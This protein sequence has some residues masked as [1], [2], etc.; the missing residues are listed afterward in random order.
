MS[1]TPKKPEREKPKPVTAPI[2]QFAVD[3]GDLVIGGEPLSRLA[4]RIGATPFFR[5]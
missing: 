2:E 4:R 5:L 3:G 1:D